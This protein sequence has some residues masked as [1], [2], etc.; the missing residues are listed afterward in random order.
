MPEVGEGDRN[1]L[2]R[3]QFIEGVEENLRIQLLQM[4]T[5]SYEETIT[6]AKQLDMASALCQSLSSTPAGIN[7]AINEPSN[8][9]EALISKLVERIEGLTVRV[10]ELSTQS[11][12]VNAINSHQSSCRPAQGACFSCGQ[13]N[14]RAA[15]CPTRQ[16]KIRATCVANV[17]TSLE[18]ATTDSET[19]ASQRE[20]DE[21]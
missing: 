5:L 6:V 17:V 10:N 1:V 14:H 4:P 15:E 13:F 11:L 16:T 3:Q 7:A 9:Q 21:D 19:K 18:I 12:A 2:L 8:R 20:T